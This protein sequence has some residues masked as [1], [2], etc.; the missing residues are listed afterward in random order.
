MFFSA[1]PATGF[2]LVSSFTAPEDLTLRAAIFSG[3]GNQ[4]LSL[5]PDF[6][7]PDQNGFTPDF[8][9]FAADYSLGKPQLF[10]FDDLAYPLLKKQTLYWGTTGPSDCQLQLFFS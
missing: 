8:Q 5:D 1:A 2:T 3:S 7:Q 6:T 4:M 10:V 9:L